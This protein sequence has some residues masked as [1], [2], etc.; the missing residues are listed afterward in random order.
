MRNDEYI[1]R[2]QLIS[3]GGLGNYFISIELE[4]LEA[5]D[6]NLTDKFRLQPLSH[7]EGLEESAAE[8]YAT[9]NTEFD[10]SSTSFQIQIT[11]K[12]NSM[13][14][15]DLKSQLINR[16]INVNGIIINAGKTL[17]KGTKITIK[18]RSCGHQKL[19]LVPKGLNELKMP[20]FCEGKANQ[21]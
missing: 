21:T 2:K 11:S 14:L 15:R 18:C 10:P 7:L 16:L 20:Y 12:E 5:Y 19:S 9:Y 4:D 8:L 6:F 13:P 1:Y 3:N 17:L